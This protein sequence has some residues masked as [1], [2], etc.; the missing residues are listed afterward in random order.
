MERLEAS[1]QDLT[2]ALAS[3]PLITAEARIDSWPSDDGA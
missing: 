3:S 1:V 2:S